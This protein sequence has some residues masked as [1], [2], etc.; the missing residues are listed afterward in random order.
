MVGVKIKDRVTVV[1]VELSLT[2]SGL[3][4]FC[5]EVAHLSAHFGTEGKVQ[6]YKTIL[7]VLQRL[8]S[9]LR[10]LGV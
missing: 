6:Q 10:E 8:D 4:K 2:S 5:R 1:N 9:E 3:S 7:E